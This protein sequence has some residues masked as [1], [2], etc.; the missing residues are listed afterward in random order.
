MVGVC[1]LT[2]FNLAFIVRGTQSKRGMM[3]KTKT[4]HRIQRRT[5]YLTNFDIDIS[6]ENHGTVFEVLDSNGNSYNVVV[7]DAK[8]HTV[9]VTNKGN[10]DAEEFV[11]EGFFIGPRGRRVNLTP[12]S[13]LPVPE[14]LFPIWVE[15]VRRL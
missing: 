7:V 11:Y 10:K 6:K 1:H 13:S 15:K 14:G 12:F 4:N 2:V 5:K 8:K 9:R 3:V